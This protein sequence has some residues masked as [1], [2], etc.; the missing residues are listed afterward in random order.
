MRQPFYGLGGGY[1]SGLE[2]GDHFGL[3]WD[4]VALYELQLAGKSV[5]P[6]LDGGIADAEYPLHLLDRS[7]TAQKGDDEYLVF[8]GQTGQGREFKAAF[9]G[10]FAIVQPDSLHLD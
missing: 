8:A 5:Q 2:L 7:V 10:R 3:R 9:N 1:L 4:R 6:V